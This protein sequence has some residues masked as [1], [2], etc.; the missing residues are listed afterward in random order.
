MNTTKMNNASRLHKDL[1]N[2]GRNGNWDIYI[3]MFTLSFY[4][5]FIG[6]RIGELLFL[7][8]NVPQRLIH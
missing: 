4:Y 6:A 2:L 3:C 8:N 1:L 7:F 5:M